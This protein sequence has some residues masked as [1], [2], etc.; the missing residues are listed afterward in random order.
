MEQIISLN[1]KKGMSLDLTKKDIT[2]K[3][4]GVGLGWKTVYDL[5][6]I[7]FLVDKNGK[8]KETV[9]YQNLNGH[10]VKLDGDDTEGGKE[11]DCE[12]ISIKFSK[13]DEDITK[14]M[15]LANIYNAK[16]TRICFG[17]VMV[18]G[19]T[20]N[21][22]QGSYIRLYNKETNQELCKYSLEENGSQYN[23][24]HF[25]DLI[26]QE[27]GT[28]TFKAIGEGMNGSIEKLR[29]QLDKIN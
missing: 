21:K 5:D 25:A 18:E 8:I 29:K 28:W 7:A 14:I 2:L 1:L 19:D 16:K 20:F 4:L 11:G 22:V 13:L 26:K 10:G 3:K 27:D 24:F 17:R 23:A 12:T 9:C 6:S 15:L